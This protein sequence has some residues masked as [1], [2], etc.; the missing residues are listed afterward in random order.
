M[1][2]PGTVSIRSADG[3]T[4]ATFVPAAGML[5]CSLLHRGEEL[6]AQN[7]GVGAYIERGATMGIPLLY[8]WANRLAGFAYGADPVVELAADSPLIKLDPG[9]LPIHGVLHSA[10][11]WELVEHEPR[12]LRAR[13]S[14][15]RAELLGLFPFPHEVGVQASLDEGRLTI[16]TSVHAGR[17]RAVPVSF[18]YH[19]YLTISG[20]DRAGWQVELPLTSRL[21]LDER[22]IPTGESEP[23][24]YPPFELGASAWDDAFDGLAAP[25]L[26]SVSAAERRIELE[27]LE[28]FR[29]AQVYSPSGASF[30]C[31]EPMTAPTNA[32]LSRR[33]LP[34]LAPGAEF[35]ASFRVSVVA[36]G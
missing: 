35:R 15:E 1:S 7:S 13:A 10:V 2:G 34:I 22:M 19:P 16:T 18:G 6:L 25:P 4:E 17:D 11:P 33:D 12:R 31:F 26:F 29:F 36:P 32:L 8:P 28:G 3:A 20:P 21:L 30:I 23:V 9:G 24:E 5:C 27:F 14:W